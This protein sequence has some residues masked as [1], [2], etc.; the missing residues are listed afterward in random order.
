MFVRLGQKRSTLLSRYTADVGRLIS[1]RQTETALRAAAVESA[2]ASRSKSEFLANMSHELR[3][4]LN[5]IIGFSELIST[6]GAASEKAHGKSVE[7]AGLIGR[8]GTHLLNII[9]DIL[10]I[11][12]IESGNFT[13][14][15]EEVSLAPLIEASVALVEPRMREKQQRLELRIAPALPRLLVDERRIK[16]AIINLLANAHK[17]TPRYGTIVLVAAADRRDFVTVAVN[18][19]GI[20]MTPEQLAHAMKPF[21]QVK[22]AYTR[23]HEGTGLGLPITKALVEQHGGRFFLSS[24]PNVGTMAAFTLPRGKPA[25]P[26]A[27]LADS[28][29]RLAAHGPAPKRSLA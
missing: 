16:Q 14:D 10:D 11:S 4:P 3:T 25:A 6:F 20:G 26:A 19:S 5:A 1:H 21:G 17:F 12:K 29:S 18:D 27:S 13:L 8:A 24:E 7:Y 23:G 15:M 2:L 22:A 28:L 9:S